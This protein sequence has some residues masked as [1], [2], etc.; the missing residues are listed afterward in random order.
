MAGGDSIHH[1]SF[2][3]NSVGMLDLNSVVIG[4]SPAVTL[5]VEHP[6]GREYA[7][8]L[9]AIADYF[10]LPVWE[11]VDVIRIAKNGE[12]FEVE[13]TE[14]FVRAW[15][16]IWAAGDFQYP[17]LNGFEGSELCQH[18]ASIDSY[19]DL[20]GDDF[21]V[22]GGYESGVDVASHLAERGKRVR[23]LIAEVPGSLRAPIQAWRFRR[24]RLSG[25]V[26][27]GMPSMWSSSQKPRSRLLLLL[28]IHLRSQQRTVWCFARRCLPS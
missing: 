8:F 21:I 24:T 6:T 17:L 15:H 9:K 22:V 3:T 2:P 12:E 5:E 23:L 28:M 16:V 7:P 26:V 25:H 4:T 27:Q 10:E 19:A 11:G 1:T 13:T 20:D 18:T 14:G